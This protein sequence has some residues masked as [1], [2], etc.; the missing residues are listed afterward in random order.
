[1]VPALIGYSV[2]KQE[3]FAGGKNHVFTFGWLL[4][5]IRRWVELLQRPTNLPLNFSDDK[6]SWKP[7]I[8]VASILRTRKFMFAYLASSIP[9]IALIEFVTL[10]LSSLL[11]LQ[12]HREMP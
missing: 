11:N 9:F 10:F 3:R 8:A 6:V 1:M 7:K 5:R 2:F 12:D 4:S